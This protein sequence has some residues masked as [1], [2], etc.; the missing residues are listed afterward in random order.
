M[1]IDTEISEIFLKIANSLDILEDNPFKIRAYRNAARNISELT[2]DIKTIAERDDLTKIP[3]IGKD[4][5]D[6]V[7]EYITSGKLNYYEDLKK[8]IPEELV[9]LLAIQGLGPKMLS[10]LFKEYHVTNLEELETALNGEDILKIH[11]MGKKK[12]EDLRRGIVIFKESKQR[13]NLGIALPLAEE[14]IREINRIHGTEGTIYAGSLRRMKETVGDIDILTI[15]DNGKQVIEEFTKMSSV[16]D[17]LASGDTKG[18]IISRNGIQVDLRVVGPGSY[19]AAL[20]YFTGSQAHNVKIRTIGVKK[21]LKIN[22]YGLFR[23]DKTIAGETEKDVYYK[24]GLPLIPPEIREDR[25]EIEAAIEGK[26]PN[27]VESNDIKGDLHVHT[28]W[29]DGTSSIEDM[30][31]KAK[32][33]GYEYI[34]ITD[35]SPS[36]RI[37]NGLSIERLYEKREELESVR[38]KVRGIQILMG[39]EVDILSDGTLD[40]PDSVLKDL[41][42]VIAS[43]HIGFKMERAK[44]T[45]RI[46]KALTNPF[47]NFLAHPTGRLIGERD[48][49]EVDLDDIFETAKKYGKAVEV[50]SHYLRLDLKDIN[51]K[52]AIDKGTDIVISTDSHHP[53]HLHQMKLGVATARRG[54]AEKKNIINTKRFKGLSNWLNG[55]SS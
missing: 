48:P 8:E 46:M 39:S 54:W 29:S 33:L 10:K 36:S 1:S 21:G 26:L 51:V 9:D 45:R 53:D 52:R 30:A 31:R 44:M 14:I 19:G 6:K 16:K 40:Y 23:G 17:V 22:E 37:A 42:V 3:G 43:V 4:L 47:V 50:N 15:A 12:I 5:A 24:L 32:K 49:Y 27:L 38:K 2:E 34:A 25:G 55:F 18:S 35:H 41:D 11:G 20:Q 28:N 7:K 13:V